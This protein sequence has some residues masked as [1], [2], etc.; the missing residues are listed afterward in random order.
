LRSGRDRREYGGVAAVLR[1][2]GIMAHRQLSTG[3][4]AAHD[5]QTWHKIAAEYPQ[6]L[7]QTCHTILYLNFIPQAL[8]I[9]PWGAL[10]N[11]V[12]GKSPA[13]ELHQMPLFAFIPANLFYLAER[14]NT[15]ICLSIGNRMNLPQRGS[16]FADHDLALRYCLGKTCLHGLAEHV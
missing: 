2:S 8:T 11:P 4:D 5:Q 9:T 10:L 6:N 1:F 16:A 12:T 7:A 15:P 3:H 14:Y 13:R